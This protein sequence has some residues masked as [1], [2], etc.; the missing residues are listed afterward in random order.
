MG[1]NATVRKLESKSTLEIRD[2]DCLSTVE[3]I[4]TAIK[5]TVG[6]S[7]SDPHISL[8][9]ENKWGLKYAVIEIEDKAANELLEVGRIKVGWV[10]CR[11]L[12]RATVVKCYKCFNYGHTQ[13]NC[14]GPDR[15]QQNLCLRC[16]EEG[17]K[18]ESCKS[19]PKCVLCEEAHLTQEKTK[20]LPG[21]K[22]CESFQNALEVAKKRL[23]RW[24]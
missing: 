5:N 22:E 2:L 23:S 8:S 1:N 3:E 17:H 18:R 20:H 13:A 14:K 21:A 11:V 10:S 24:K 9:K 7:V 19:P 4:G 15:R 6:N 12:Q 16:G